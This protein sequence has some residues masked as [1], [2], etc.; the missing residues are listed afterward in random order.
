L[1]FHGGTALRFLFSD[2]YYSEDLD[3]ALEGNRESYNFRD[4]LKTIRSDFSPEG[5]QIEIKANDQKTVNSAFVRFPGL[6]FELGLS[7]MQN[8]VIAVKMEVNTNSPLEAG[9]STTIV[10]RFVVLQIHHHDKASLLSGKLHVMRSCNVLTQRG[11]MFMTCFG[12]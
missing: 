4:Y 6:L 3:F 7:P 10:R 12:I 5:Y 8:E 11:A 1:A 9:L 2:G